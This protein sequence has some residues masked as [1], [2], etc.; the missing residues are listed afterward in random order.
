MSVRFIEPI[1]LFTKG[2]VDDNTT[3]MTSSTFNQFLAFVSR[4]SMS[5]RNQMDLLFIPCHIVS[6]L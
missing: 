1:S 4:Q 2:T 6:Y 5:D 3:P